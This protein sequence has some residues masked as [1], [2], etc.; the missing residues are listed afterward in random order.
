MISAVAPPAA[1]ANASNDLFPRSPRRVKGIMPLLIPALN[2]K[3]SLILNSLLS[4][5]LQ[6]ASLIAR[7]PIADKPDR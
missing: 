5:S 2:L 6:G 4:G 3:L 1:A 7:H